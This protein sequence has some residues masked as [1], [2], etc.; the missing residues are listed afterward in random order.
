MQRF[1]SEIYLP[2]FDTHTEGEDTL[3]LRPGHIANYRVKTIQAGNML[4][5]EIFPIWNT[6]GESTN[7]VKAIRKSRA[8]VMAANE[9][10][11]RK[12]LIRKINAN[13]TEKDLHMT[14][15]YKGEQPGPEQA[16]KDMQNYIRR[17]KAYRKANGLSE[18][19]YVYVVEDME[20][21]RKKRIHH[22]LVMSGMDRDTAEELWAKG[23]ANALKLQPDEYGLEGLARYII[24]N[25]QGS[26]RWC[27][28]KNLVDPIVKVSDKRISK[29]RVEL[30]ARDMEQNA[31]EIFEKLYPDYCFNDCEVK[32]S[33]Y[34]SGAYIYTRM[35]R[36]R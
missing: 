5:C 28:S 13:F 27:T 34:V 16:R 19:K 1:S 36:R 7:A 23:R 14:L 6:R 29:R 33:E 4:E 18:I 15:T 24:K 31:K 21:T 2:L 20:G 8:A 3:K 10:N 12:K 25:P 9:R 11:A 32:R 17:I 22:H 30:I 26:K 35:R